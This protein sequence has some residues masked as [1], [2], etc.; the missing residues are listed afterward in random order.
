[1][2]T[3]LTLANGNILVGINNRGLVSDFFFPYVGVENH[4]RG[5]SHRIGVWQHGKLSWLTDDVWDITVCLGNDSFVGTTR[6][7][8]KETN[9]ELLFTD[10][11]YNEKNIFIREVAVTNHSEHTEE[12]KLFFHQVFSIYGTPQEDTTYFDPIKNTIIQYEGRRVFMIYGEVSDIPFDEYSVGLYGIE[13]KEGTFRD[14][15]DGILSKNPIEH[16]HV[17]STLSLSITVQA[18][19]TKKAHYWVTVGETKAEVYELHEYVKY[20]RATHL[21]DAT[22]KFWRAWLHRHT[23]L[24]IDEKESKYIDLFK[25]SLFYIRGNIDNR[26]A[27]LASGDSTM[28][29]NGRDTYSYMWPRDGAMTVLALLEVGEYNISK[30]FFKFCNDVIEP[31]GYLMH[32]YR[33]DKSPGSSWHPFIR[34]DKHI[35]PIQE[36]ETALM[37]IA[38][39]DYY[40]KTKDIEFIDSHYYSVIKKAANFLADFIDH[41]SGLPLPSYDLWEE[42]Y[43]VSTFTACTVYGALQSAAKFANLFEKE[44]T[45]HRYQM[46][47]DRMREAILQTLYDKD[48][49]MFIKMENREN[50]ITTR[51]TTIDMSS[52]YAIYTYGILDVHHPIVTECIQ[53]IENRLRLHEGVDG[54]PRY[55]GDTYYMRVEGKPNPWYITTLWLAQYYALKAETASDLN[56]VRYWLNWVVLHSSHSG[57]LSEQ[58]HPFTGEQLSAT[59][60]TWSHAEY[61]RTILRYNEATIRITKPN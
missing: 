40:E 46:V 2:S 33:A 50:G 44:N 19:E 59:P 35:L 11:V 30:H 16:G 1:M 7:Y 39:W 49:G 37:L 42:K 29:Q 60:L 24:S 31:D 52:I 21:I 36:D 18:N 8:N 13:G 3:S 10:V 22:T 43:G 51:D 12:I 27:I 4:V 38:L 58:I 34:H 9:L 45:E 55:E 5:E 54:I 47:A 15:E 48:L 14:A 53:T 56:T 20:K 57:V 32:K 23:A 6:C 61:I 26:G 41:D 17:D 25:K 28:L